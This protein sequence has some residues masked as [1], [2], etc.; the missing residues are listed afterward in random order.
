MIAL[1]ADEIFATRLR[2]NKTRSLLVAISG[3]DGCGKSAFG[4]KLCEELQSR[5]LNPALINLD[6]WHTPPEIR[7][8]KKRPGEHFYKHAFRFQDLF[9]LL[10][11]PLKKN[12]SIHLKVELIR[13]PQNDFYPHTY[14]FCEV[15]IIVLEGILLL[16]RE[17]RAQYDFSVWIDCPF[18]TALERAIV[19][20]QEGLSVEELVREYNTIYFPAQKIHLQRDDPKS[21]A[22][23]V[24][25]NP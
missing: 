8:N 11:D 3:I 5:N 19:R 12:R 25:N 18:E 17:L 1:I 6:A 21:G 20:N 10:I 16:K 14:D 23:R 13:L 4:R 24:I 22:T 2:R 9:G 15:D 7:F